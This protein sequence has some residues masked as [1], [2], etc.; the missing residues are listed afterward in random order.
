L[1][2]QEDRQWVQQQA[3]R[4]KTYLD[5]NR[6]LGQRSQTDRAR[7]IRLRRKVQKAIDDLVWLAEVWPPDQQ[8]RVF[9]TENIAKLASNLL[10]KR[11]RNEAEK[12][13]EKR[14]QRQYALGAMFMEKGVNKCR[15]RVT[16]PYQ[17]R[18][19]HESLALMLTLKKAA[20]RS[21][22][23]VSLNV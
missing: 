17:D 14:E 10:K 2:R 1:L 23:G 16:E 6:H 20:L 7:D 22:V 12:D 11:Y 8:N 13:R 21:D 3:Q 9:T 15:E 19:L 18:Y 5:P 4:Y